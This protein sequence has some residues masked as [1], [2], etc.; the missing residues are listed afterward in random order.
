M[1]NIYV[2]NK[3]GEAIAELSL[4]NDLQFSERL[5]NYGTC[6]FTLPISSDKFKYIIPRV[7]EIEIRKGSQ[8]VWAGEIV[9]ERGGLQANSANRSTIISYTYLEML[10]SRYTGDYRR[11]DDIDQGTML[12]TLIDESQ[13][14]TDGNLGFTVSVTATKNRDREYS[15]FNIMEA[16]I[17]MSNLTDGIEFDFKFNK[18]IE[19]KSRIGLD[20]SSH[21]I[22]EW[23]RNLKALS[24]TKDFVNPGNK[25]IVL[26]SGFG[27]AQAFG[28]ATDTASRGVYKLREQRRSEID[29]STQAVLD[30]KAS[31][32]VR[33]HKQPIFS[34]DITQLENTEPDFPTLRIGDLCKFKVKEGNLNVD[35]KFRVYETSVT[36]G[37]EGQEEVT[38]FIGL[39]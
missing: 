22:F 10:N 17:N 7:N 6:S 15:F 11:F 26:G 39:L 3:A 1:Y 2:K 13:A 31:D 37:N 24:Y 19:I 27:S 28:T 20:R 8:V 21:A 36:I 16:Y 34:F 5:N 9:A 18:E 29:V 30:D 38:Y 25:A 12:K 4:W 35:N 32:L 23:G 33:I 14:Q